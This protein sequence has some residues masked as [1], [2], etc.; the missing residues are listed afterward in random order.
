VRLVKEAVHAIDI[1][2]SMDAPTIEGRSRTRL[3]RLSGDLKVIYDSDGRPTEDEVKKLRRSIRRWIKT[4]K[5]VANV[6]GEQMPEELER[7]A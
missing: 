2:R 5:M 7:A 3:L 6:I 1:Q 4:A